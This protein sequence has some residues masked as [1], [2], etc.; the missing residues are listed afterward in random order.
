MLDHISNL[1]VFVPNPLDIVPVAGAPAVTVA[2]FV[3]PNRSRND[4]K[5]DMS[6]SGMNGRIPIGEKRIVNLVNVV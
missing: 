2:A 6:F 4:S 5:C 1:V 3:S